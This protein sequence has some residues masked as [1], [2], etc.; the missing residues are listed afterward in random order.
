M[1]YLVKGA[2]IA[3]GVTLV[4]AGLAFFGAF[5]RMELASYDLRF[6]IR[7]VRPPQA[8]IDRRSRTTDVVIIA[9]D[10]Q[11]LEE[12]QLIW[13]FSRSY[14][15]KAIRNLNRAGAKVIGL[16]IELFTAKDSAGDSLLANV[17]R[18]TDN[19][20]ISRKVKAERGVFRQGDLRFVA[21]KPIPLFTRTGVELGNVDMIPDSDGFI[22]RALLVWKEAGNL[23]LS[24]KLIN[25]FENSPAKFSHAGKHLLI[26]GHK[27]PIASDNSMLIDYVAPSSGFTTY[28]FSQVYDSETAWGIKLLAEKGFLKDK[29]VLIGATF[30]EAHDL[31]P[32]PFYAG[33]RIFSKTKCPMSGVEIQANIIDTVLTDS[34]IKRVGG[35]G[36]Y[37][38]LLAVTLALCL[39]L[40]KLRALGGALITLAVMIAYSIGALYVFDRWRVWV[41]LVGPLGGIFLTYVGTVAYRFVAEQKEKRMIKGAFSHFVPGNVVRELLKN[42]EMLRLGGEERV[43][44]VMFSDLAGFTTMSESL[45]ATALCSFLNEYLTEMT[46]VILKYEGIIDKYEADLIMAE[47]GAPLPLEDHARRACLAAIEMQARLRQLREKWHPEGKPQA[48]ARIGINTGLMVV[49]NMGSRN[50]FDYTVL[51]DSVNV[52][53]RL[54]TANKEYGTEIMIGEETY[55]QAKADLKVRELDVIRVKGRTQPVR[56]YELLAEPGTA[57]SFE[58]EELLNHFSQGLEDY[59]NWRWK[60]AIAHFQAALEIA[61]DD[62]PSL[63]LLSRCRAFRTIPPPEDWD[64]IYQQASE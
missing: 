41:N 28:S 3:L 8:A 56:V 12:L 15:A 48:R 60:E 6:R 10:D 24:T 50:I 49:G 30:T 59:K 47:F 54:E 61:P 14:Y 37:G 45:P 57:L 22:R 9:I 23:F 25:L 33:D 52:A 34:F 11:S 55:T 44:T 20:V 4:T 51:G 62:G 17:L 58:K 38:L 39:A 36:L 13:P 42:P 40:L 26:G 31:H 5:E 32:T 46:E 27:I 1:N 19:V 53:S 7:G 2:V 18:E 63:A 64:G 29:I 35:L 21:V 43:L 16:D